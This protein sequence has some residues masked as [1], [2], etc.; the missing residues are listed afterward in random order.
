MTNYLWTTEEDK[1]GYNKD[2]YVNPEE[3]DWGKHLTDRL[4][5]DDCTDMG[6]VRCKK[7]GSFNSH[8]TMVEHSD[9]SKIANNGG[10]RVETTCEY[11]G[12]K[13]D[14]IIGE[15]KGSVLIYRKFQDEV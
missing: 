3:L 1:N 12:H 5:E 8:I 4:P 14:I 9:D 13:S 7:C 10:V 11:C 2:A 6:L 15:H